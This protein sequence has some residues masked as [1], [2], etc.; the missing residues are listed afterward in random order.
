LKEAE[1][2]LGELSHAVV[3]GDVH[4]ARK[5]AEQV[6]NRGISTSGALEKLTEAMQVADKKIQEERVFCD[7]RSRRSLSHARGFRGF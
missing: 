7:R 2:L 5:I 1:E 4:K 3:L 6:V